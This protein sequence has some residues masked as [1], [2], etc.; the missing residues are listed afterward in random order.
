[1]NTRRLAIEGAVW[2][3]I[4]LGGIAVSKLHRS[5]TSLHLEGEAAASQQGE[6]A[7]AVFNAEVEK[8]MMVQ[9]CTEWAKAHS[10]EP[11]VKMCTNR[12]A[13]SDILEHVAAQ[14]YVLSYTP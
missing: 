5:S 8:R 3:V 13:I 9:D 2:T 10:D 12:T 6:K 1:M 7:A 11:L 4:I 14:T